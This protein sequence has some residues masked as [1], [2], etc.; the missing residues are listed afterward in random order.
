MIL[1]VETIY[2]H[3]HLLHF[4]FHRISDSESESEPPKDPKPPKGP[5]PHKKTQS[6]GGLTK[7]GSNPQPSKAQVLCCHCDLP[8]SIRKDRLKKHTLNKHP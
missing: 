4:I 6:K 1:C 7:G 2:Y 8:V 3:L 5:E